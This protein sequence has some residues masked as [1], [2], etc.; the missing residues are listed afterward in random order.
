MNRLSQSLRASLR[1]ERGVAIPLVLGISLVIFVL[2]VSALSF[3]VSGLK[4]ANRDADRAAALAAA[5]AG[6]D[7]Y[8]S[9]LAN[10]SRYQRYGNPDAPFT[11]ATGSTSSV[12]LPPSAEENPAFGIGETG[13]WATM[14]GTDGR[15]AFRYEVDNSGYS[16]TGVL[17]IRSTGKVGN[18]TQSIVA[19][20]KQ[21]GFIDFLYF[22]DYEILDPSIFDPACQIYH[23]TPSHH[24]SCL[25][26]QFGTA[27][28]LDGPVHSNDIMR[29]CASKFLRKVTTGSTLSTPQYVKPSGC[30]DGQF[31]AAINA[32]GVVPR[33]E[34]MDMPP[35]NGEMKIE[36]RID[37]PDIARPGCMY[38]GPTT[39]RFNSAG[40]VTV[41]SPWT[42][43]T[44][45]SL[46]S[47][48]PSQSP[49]E[50]GSIA[51]LN[52]SAG[53][54]FTPPAQNL[55]YVQNVPLSSSD[56][57]YWASNSVPSRFTCNNKSKSNEGWSYQ[58]PTNSSAT[59][60]YPVANEV[61]PTTSTTQAPAYG[62]RN[63]DAFVQGT[64]KG[65][66][67]VASDNFI[68]ITG[69]LT[70][71]NVATDV[72]GLVGNNAVWVWNPM[73][74]SS[75]AIYSA[76]NRTIHAAI[77]S[78]GHSFIV[79]NYAM[80]GSRG[81]LTVIGAIAQKFRGPVGNTAPNG[82]DKNYKYDDRLFSISPPKFLLPM[83]TTYGVTQ[84][85]M[86]SPAFD[87]TGAPAS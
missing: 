63:G 68:Y 57:N 37:L 49:A 9:R 83:S 30:S 82:Y 44:Q 29:I 58:A 48:I 31:S 6:I 4:V 41:V 26:I 79:Q 69:D 38:T 46:T 45:P 81:T 73:N 28:V 84:Y 85:A 67:T 72:L 25:E 55:L 20:L 66:V 65:Q 17:R 52:S 53:A 60:R 51:A 64:V 13:T 15:A 80:G 86:V 56:P 21:S 59:V 18:E 10:D 47:G 1:D 87:A 78:V 75:N 43:V 27:D 34:R 33:V 12:V 23:G 62:C 8:S 71:Q 11:I 40:T 50:C 19:D 39:I 76:K 61:I 5:Y 14:A 35:T 70:Y 24:S 7:E 2:I 54:T 42:R 3:S 74:S 77:L 32:G 36:S 16:S 22:T